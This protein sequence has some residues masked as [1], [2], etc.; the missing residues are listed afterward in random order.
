[1]KRIFLS[2]AFIFIAALTSATEPSWPIR[3]NKAEP[4]DDGGT[5]AYFSTDSSGHTF[6]FCLDRRLKTST[7][8]S[9]YLSVGHPNRKGATLLRKGSQKEREFLTHVKDSLDKQ[10]GPSKE[11]EFLKRSQE[12][13]ATLDDTSRGVAALLMRILPVE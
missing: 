13:D 6:V 10:F 11:N 7:Y 1:M 9:F 8:D 5:I 3:I 4:Y 2:F 12:N